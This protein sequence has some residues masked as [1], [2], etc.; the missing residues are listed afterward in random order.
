M[1]TSLSLAAAAVV[2]T[3]PLAAQSLTLGKGGGALPG[4]STFPVTGPSNEPYFLLM[5][6]S[7][8]QTAIPSLG[9]TLEVPLDLAGFC[10]DGLGWFGQMPGS[11]QVDLDL[12][13]PSLPALE[14]LT[15]SF[16]AIGGNQL[17][18]SNLVRMTPQRS[19]TFLAGRDQPDLPILGGGYAAAP[20]GTLL[21]VGGTGPAAQSYDPMLE[22]WSLAG[23]SFGV[24]LLSQTTGLADGRVLFT[25]GLGLNGQ[26]TDAA[27]V[28][29]PA[30][31]Q[32]VTLAMGTARAGH[33]AALMGDGRV[34]ITGGLSQV[35]LTNPLSI[36]TSILNSSE[37][38]DP[39][40]GAFTPGANMLEA[41]ALHSA[42]TLTNG[43]V[44]VA[45]GLAVLPIVNLPNVSS[46]AYR[47]N[48]NSGS[49]GL[50]ALMSGG[51]LLHTAVALDDGKVL[52]VGGLTLDLS[53]FLQS[54]NIADIIIGTR[55]DCQLYN[56][57]LFG[58]GTFSTVDG[59]QE[60]RAGAAVAAL[61]G[62]GALIAGGFQ[63]AIDIPSQTFVANAT[64]SADVF[65]Q[66]PNRLTPTG[67]MAAP[68]LFPSTA[69]LPDG[70]V[71]V[72]G[73][74]PAQVEIYQR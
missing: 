56:R 18:T 68:R 30:T 31:Q 27:A 16:Q 6:F 41:R 8:Q 49:F 14:G 67:D 50:P 48:P 64:A 21:F 42:T 46:T 74:G 72:L 63:L 15:V 23:A 28:Y 19:G 73:G 17:Q 20:D 60:G 45:G 5:A 59:M 61:P 37:I 57:G 51:R 43:E 69:T 36:F 40:T 22:E 70:T 65:A 1:K 54:G 58:F 32:T 35:D 62:G 24:G 25:G 29:D 12:Q 66:G 11:G 9:I 53:A 44:L 7:E 34:L 33:G 13:L 3:L 52:L 2:L 4:T 26:P 10:A 47:Y 38:Y 71:M 55:T 39:A